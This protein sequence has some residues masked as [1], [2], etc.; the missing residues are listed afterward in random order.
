M[1]E[2]RAVFSQ[3]MDWFP[4]Y[5]FDKCVRRYNGN[6]RVKK[7]SC[8]EQ[9]LTMAFAQLTY[10]ESLRDIETC[11]R[12]LQ[13]KLYHCGIRARVSRSTLADANE[14]RDC[15][16]FGDF[17]QVLIGKARRLYA[18]DEFGARLKQTAYVLDA[19]TIDLCLALFPWA[20]FRRHKSAIKLHTLFDLR[21]NIPTL[22]LVTS[23]RV[24]DGTMLQH[25][26]IEPGSFYIMDRAYRDLVQLHRIHQQQAFFL[27]RT[28]KHQDLRRLYSHPIDKAVGLQCDQTVLFNG[29]LSKTKYPDK[30]RR[31][32]YRDP[33]T[34]K[35]LVFLTNNFSIP[36]LTVADLYRCRWQVELFFKWIKQ[37]LRIKA[38]YGTSVNAVKTQVWIAIAIY[39]LVAIIK[40]ELH[41]Q[42]SL[43]TILQ[44]LSV[45]LFEKTPIS[46]AFSNP[47]Y[48]SEHDICEKAQE[49]RLLPGF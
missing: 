33:L 2:G 1:K 44:I 15:R 11:L 7:F 6:H 35:R 16:I 24:F 13:P 49:Q 31:V 10:R 12:T 40:K 27:I 3:L 20:Q 8:W 14:R 22:V 25:I 9:F 32:R 30:L 38:F 17:A 28:V 18:T 48:I 37:H 36:A 46:E 26:A 4:K 42:H 21:G 43:Y 29:P 47:I 34:Q 19:T 41:L 45:T 5:E 39:L 23:G